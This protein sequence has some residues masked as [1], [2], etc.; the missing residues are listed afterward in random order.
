LKSGNEDKVDLMEPRELRELSKCQYEELDPRDPRVNPR[1][2]LFRLTG[3]PAF[4][5]SRSW[6]EINYTSLES[7][8]KASVPDLEEHLA[9]LIARASVPIVTD[10]ETQ[11][12]T[13]LTRIADSLETI[14]SKPPRRA[15][16]EGSERARVRLLTLDE[17]VHDF[18]TECL[19]LT[20]SERDFVPTQLMRDEFSHWHTART[21]GR[22]KYFSD[23][24]LDKAFA[25]AGLERP[26]SPR[27]YAGRKVRGFWS[28]KIKATAP[29]TK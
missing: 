8:L 7:I 13:Q 29:A 27:V 16:G 6:L 22:P 14:A 5:S 23:I 25:R 21:G 18:I 3:E 26:P 1:R 10:F 17:R 28:V 11:L 20:D 15:H 12:I 9:V 2:L 24:E 4:Q 19:E